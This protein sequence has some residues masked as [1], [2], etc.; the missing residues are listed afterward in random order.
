MNKKIY[1][2]KSK[3]SGEWVYGGIA[4]HSDGAVYIIGDI[5]KQDSYFE[6]WKSAEEVYPITVGEYTGIPDK[7]GAKIFEGDIVVSAEYKDIV[8][9]VIYHDGGFKLLRNDG[10]YPTA[11]G[12]L[13]KHLLVIGN[14]HDNPEMLKEKE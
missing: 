4:Y 8:R 10:R 11:I 12:K 6:L 1:R 7:N 9:A 13:K 3:K 5:A 2:G 14:I